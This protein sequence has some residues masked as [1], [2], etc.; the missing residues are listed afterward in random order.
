VDARRLLS[1]CVEGQDDSAD[2]AA[3]QLDRLA[4]LAI[5]VLV[6]PLLILL[7]LLGHLAAEP[8]AL[9]A[10]QLARILEGSDCGV[11]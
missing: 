7:H 9:V 10:R 2:L 6:D 11:F 3:G 4:R 5:D 8:G 1:G